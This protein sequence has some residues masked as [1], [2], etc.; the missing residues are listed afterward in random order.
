[1][2]S[3]ADKAPSLHDVLL[4]IN[5]N[6]DCVL[7]DPFPCARIGAA[8]PE[9]V[10]GYDHGASIDMQSVAPVVALRLN[11]LNGSRT[12]LTQYSVG[13]HQ[14]PTAFI[15]NHRLVAAGLAISQAERRDVLALHNQSP[16]GT[17]PPRGTLGG[18]KT[19]VAS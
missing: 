1:M 6:V 4:A 15:K 7:A 11:H 17:K 8:L 14:V 19:I 5:V 3:D 16:I 18:A 9:V 2:A 12:C 13:A 10:R